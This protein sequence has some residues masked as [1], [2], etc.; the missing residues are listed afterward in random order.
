MDNAIL[1]PSLI[2]NKEKRQE[3]NARRKQLIN[4]IKKKAKL[5][6]KKEEAVDPKKREARLQ[7]NVPKTLENTREHDETMVDADDEEV[8]QDEQHDEFSP[9]FERAVPPKIVIT[10]SL[11]ASAPVYEIAQEFTQIFPNAEFVKR[12]PNY[13]IKHMVKFASNRAYTDLIILNEHRKEV[14]AVTVIHLPEG[15]TMHFKLTNFIPGKAI[16]NHGRVDP[17]EPELVLNNFNTRLGHQV[18]R[19]LASLF[20]LQPQFKG[21]QVCT[22]H[23]QRDFIFFRRHRY[24]FRDG[25]R[26][27]L[28]ELG[29]R[30]TLKLQWV[31]KGTFDTKYGD[32]EWKWAPDMQTSRR[33]FFL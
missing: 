19:Q 31:Q 7:K 2:R 13:D 16:H 32:Y 12:K 33:R 22:F 30:F 28:Q 6:R 29:P 4:L 25:E 17:F 5:R 26:A 18:G 20:P 14:N 8:M 1:D 11:G 10:T 3:V 24:V 23:N 15:P 21:R 9:Y 27:D